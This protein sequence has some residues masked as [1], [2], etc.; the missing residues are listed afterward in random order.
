MPS[1]VVSALTLERIALGEIDGA[2]H[3][4][5]AD[6]ARLAA[7]RADNAATL[8]RMPR[9]AVVA[10]VQRTLALAAD[11]PAPTRAHRARSNLLVLA[12]ALAAACVFAFAVTREPAPAAYASSDAVEAPAE[13]SNDDVTI[14]K[15][16]AP[17]LF[18]YL[19]RPAE[20]PEPLTVGAQ[21]RAGDRLQLSMAPAGRAHAVVV[22]IDGRGH[23]TLHFPERADGSTAVERARDEVPLPH[24]FVL[25]DAPSF[26]R[27]VIVTTSASAAADHPIDVDDVLAAA[28]AIAGTAAARTALLPLA[29]G[30]E[31]WS[32][33]VDK[34]AP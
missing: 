17:A 12:P 11:A 4:V 23:V 14:I 29:P 13:G 26:E 27:F 31:Q 7:L 34:A 3:G 25:D 24:S 1:P 2:P 9:D 20:A 22:S 10:R 18:V 19:V 16:I 30:V 28:D 5:A 8:A 21:A 33:I 6:D 15:G 32:R